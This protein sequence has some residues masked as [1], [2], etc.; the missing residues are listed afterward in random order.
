MG[1]HPIPQKPSNKIEEENGQKEDPFQPR[2]FMRRDE[3]GLPEHREM[4]PRHFNMHPQRETN[5]RNKHKMDAGVRQRFRQELSESAKME[6]MNQREMYSQ[7]YQDKAPTRGS[8]GKHII[9]KLIFCF[10]FNGNREVG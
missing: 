8:K 7:G 10:W 2:N 4:I 9:L 1:L 3:P 5:P 6:Q